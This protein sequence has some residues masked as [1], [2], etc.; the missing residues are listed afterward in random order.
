[1]TLWYIT[2]N[3]FFISALSY[4]IRVFNTREDALN[5]FDNSHVTIIKMLNIQGPLLETEE[6]GTVQSAYVELT[7]LTSGTYFM[8]LK[9]T[10]HSGKTS[11][12]SNVVELSYTELYP[13]YTATGFSNGEYY[14]FPV[15]G[16]TTETNRENESKEA[17]SADSNFGLIIGLTC[18]FLFLL[19]LIGLILFFYFE[20]RKKKKNDQNPNLGQNA[21]M[22]ESSDALCRS[23]GDGNISIISP[24][25]SWNADSLITH[26]QTV[27]R[28]KTTEDDKMLTIPENRDSDSISLSSTKY[29]YDNKIDINSSI[30]DPIY[31]HQVRSQEELHNYSCNPTYT[32]FDPTYTSSLRRLDNRDITM[33]PYALD[34]ISYCSYSLNRNHL[35]RLKTDV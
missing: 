14:T 4:D 6:A 22:T 26:Y 3:L 1:M 12:V 17:L 7:N 23:N 21:K 9:T 16:T 30:Y 20:R 19:I 11:D 32:P 34:N 28:Q 24:V 27:Q 35:S 10:S 2:A 8:A 5:D 29:S 25:N 18:G 15:Y 33:D 13:L 31:Y